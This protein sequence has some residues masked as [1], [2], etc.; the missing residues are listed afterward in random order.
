MIPLSVVI[1]T[2]KE[3]RLR[4]CLESIKLAEEIIIV[5]DFSTD[6][7]C[8]IAR[9]YTDK[10]FQKKMEIEGYEDGIFR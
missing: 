1:I 2:K 4:E 6:K 10:I 3:D 5:D 9:E 8:D 7:T